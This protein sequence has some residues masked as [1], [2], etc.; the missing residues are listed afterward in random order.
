MSTSKEYHKYVMDNLLKIGASSRAMMGEYV[1]YYKDKVVGG[2]YDNKVL[3][4][5]VESAKNMLP[6]AELIIPYISAKPMLYIESIEDSEFKLNLFE[7]M[8]N[9]L[10]AKKS[11]KSDKK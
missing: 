3:I 5:P 6:N 9:E 1:L 11:T 2:I 10:P 7:S 4:K 8:Y